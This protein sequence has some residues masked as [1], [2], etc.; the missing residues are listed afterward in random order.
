QS[1]DID[2]FIF[3]RPSTELNLFMEGSVPDST[4]GNIYMFTASSLNGTTYKTAT[5]HINADFGEQMNLFIDA[6]RMNDTANMNLFIGARQ[7]GGHKDATLFLCN[8][9]LSDS[10][11]FSMFIDGPVG[12]GENGEMNLFIGGEYP[13]S[14]LW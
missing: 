3:N 2:L 9:Y 5:M 8:E 11:V 6:G 1:E 14:G 13:E 12:S 7:S 10:G 4:S